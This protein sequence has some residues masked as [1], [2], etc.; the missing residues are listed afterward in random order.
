MRVNKGG[1]RAP[2]NTK[3]VELRGA[4]GHEARVIKSFW[5]QHTMDQ[6]IS[7]TQEELDLAIDA[8]LEGFAQRQIKNNPRWNWPTLRVHSR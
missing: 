7:M 3:P 1:K 5:T 6:V 2:Y 8:Y 4:S